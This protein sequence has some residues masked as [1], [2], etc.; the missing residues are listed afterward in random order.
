MRQQIGE[1]DVDVAQGGARDRGEATYKMV[2]ADAPT[3]ILNINE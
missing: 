2:D 3:R 1:L